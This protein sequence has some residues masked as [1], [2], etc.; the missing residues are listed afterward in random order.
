MQGAGF[1]PGG[2][3]RF[4]INGPET[5]GNTHN[6]TGA[7]VAANGTFNYSSTAAGDYVSNTFIYKINNVITVQAYHQTSGQSAVSSFYHSGVGTNYN[8]AY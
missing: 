6:G 5:R 8:A 7:A 1:T 2:V 3:I 4:F